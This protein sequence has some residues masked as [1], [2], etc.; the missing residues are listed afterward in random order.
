[1]PDGGQM[2]NKRSTLES[3]LLSVADVYMYT[4]CNL[5]PDTFTLSFHFPE[6]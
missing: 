3:I 6:L 5:D 1:M 4:V 2:S